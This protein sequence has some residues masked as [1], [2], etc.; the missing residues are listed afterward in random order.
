MARRY[1]G[2]ALIDRARA[3]GAVL[4]DRMM[5]SQLRSKV[6]YG[7]GAASALFSGDG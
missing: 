2:E 5:D 1:A 3:D 6:S 7:R 4:A